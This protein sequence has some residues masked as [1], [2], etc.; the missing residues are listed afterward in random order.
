LTATRDLLASETQAEETS[1]DKLT[2]ELKAATAIRDA[3]HAEYNAAHTD[4]S[5]AHS[6]LTA[7]ITHISTTDSTGL[8]AVKS[9]VSKDANHVAADDKQKIATALA[10]AGALNI[11]DQTKISSLLQQIPDAPETDYDFHSNDI[12]DTLR[13]LE[14]TYGQKKTELENEESAAA[15]AFTAA[16]LAKRGQM[17]ESQNTIDTK[18]D[19]RNTAESDMATTL[20]DL[21]E[22]TAL[23]ND[24]NTYLK[25]LTGQCERKAREWDQR[26]TL[27][28][29]ELE[30]ISQALT[31]ISG[32]VAEKATAS[33]NGGRPEVAAVQVQSSSD[34]E[35]ESDTYSDVVFAQ[36]KTV[37]AADARALRSK[38]ITMLKKDSTKLKSATLALIV[39]QL[40]ADPFAKVK[41]LI[42]KLI[43]RL[44][45]EKNDEATHKGWCD[46]EIKTA[47]TDRDFRHTETKNLAA[48]IR[49]LEARKVSLEDEISTLQ[50]DISNLNTAHTDASNA[51]SSEKA[52]N[53]ATLEAAQQGHEALA[54]AIT[55]LEDFYRQAG[56]ATTSFVQVSTSQ[57]PV[58]KDLAD[59]GGVHRGAYKGNQTGANGILGMLATIK[60]DFERTLSETTAAENQA[61]RDFTK[62]SKETKASIASKERGE[63][64]ATNDLSMTNGDLNAQLLDLESNQ[65]MIDES[66]R[67][68]TALRPACVDTGMS[69]D[70]RVAAREAEIAALKNAVCVL[71]EADGV[72]SAC[73]TLFLQKN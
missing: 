12:L 11:G 33:G 59:A 72:E 30:A 15:N 44:L 51:R 7:A 17:T 55:I 21:T 64:N 57:S 63:Q 69:Y 37:H 2:A 60:S 50:T 68:L 66:L 36:L 25:D 1:L 5:A 10:L 71:D 3:E 26:S 19:Q 8:L 67:A 53:K 23:L 49:V 4:I 43:E 58:S 56:R 9:K 61:S 39:Q 13:G 18:T 52:E 35:T 40:A 45:S 46:T 42:Q 14:T 22:T 54:R 27:R 32:T 24:D 16:A 20:T 41:T 62:F 38:V 48:S 29:N 70:E 31:I 47:E 34:D 65:R 73:T 28:K 6:G